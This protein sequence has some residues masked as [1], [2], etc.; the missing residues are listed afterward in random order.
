MASVLVDSAVPGE[1]P[2]GTGAMTAPASGPCGN[3][4][5]PIRNRRSFDF[6]ARIVAGLSALLAAPLAA[7]APVQA[8][9]DTHETELRSITMTTGVQRNVR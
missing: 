4:P 1:S 2:S 3:P 6:G 8:Q 5:V 9:T 7:H